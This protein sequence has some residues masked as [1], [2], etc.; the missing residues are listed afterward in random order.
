MTLRHFTSRGERRAS[1]RLSFS[2]MFAAIVLGLFQAG[3][4]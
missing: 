4:L 1:C 3:I 2:I